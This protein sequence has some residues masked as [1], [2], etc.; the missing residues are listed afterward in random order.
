MT[1]TLFEQY[2]EIIGPPK[3]V[4]ATQEHLDEVGKLLDELERIEIFMDAPNTSKDDY[5]YAE[6]ERDR[7]VDILHTM[8]EEV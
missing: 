2:Q 4:L 8:V 3:P 7:L 6:I 1:T 5:H